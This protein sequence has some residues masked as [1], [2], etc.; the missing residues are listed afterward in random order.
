M[1]SIE[2][3]EKIDEILEIENFEVLLV[4]PMDLSASLGVPG[5]IHHPKVE[6]IMRNVAEKMNGMNKSLATTFFDPKDAHRWIA[7]GYRMMNV[8]SVLQ[9][10][11]DRTKEIFSDLRAEFS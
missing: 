3:Y 9:L 10:G 11:T 8:G 1:E 7:E 2:A 5:E 4:G 6:S